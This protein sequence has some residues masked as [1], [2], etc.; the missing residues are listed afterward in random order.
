MTKQIIKHDFSPELRSLSAS[1]L[2]AKKRVLDYLDNHPEITEG[3]DYIRA[4]FKYTDISYE[5]FGEEC[6]NQKVNRTSSLIGTPLYVSDQ[7]PHPKRSDG[8]SMLPVLQFDTRWI[9]GLCSKNL[10]PCLLQFWWDSEICEGLFRKLPF[11][12]VILEKVKQID[13]EDEVLEAGP[14]WI[15]ENWIT[16]SRNSSFQLLECTPIGVTHPDI[17]VGIDWLRD[18]THA[19]AVPQEVWDDLEKF[20]YLWSRFTIDANSKYFRLGKL[21]GEFYAAQASPVDMEF[22]GCLINM[23]WSSGYGSIF[24]KTDEK[25]GKT[26]FFFYFDN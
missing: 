17:Q 8:K 12:E 26:E 24:Y 6:F 9:N 22:D 25:S 10:E 14:D 16:S 7:H 4:C 11:S 20:V 13:L 5:F 15:D 21:F 23:A 19:D 1:A 18:D 2:D 3:V